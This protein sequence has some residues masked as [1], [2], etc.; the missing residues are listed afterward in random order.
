MSAHPDE[1]YGMDLTLEVVEVD[2]GARTAVMGLT[3]R[4]A[5]RMGGALLGLSGEVSVPDY[6]AVVGANG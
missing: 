6:P 5:N 3:P 2:A 1:W 4:Q